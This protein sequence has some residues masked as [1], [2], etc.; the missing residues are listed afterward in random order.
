MKRGE[1]PGQWKRQKKNE[2]KELSLRSR[3]RA[4]GGWRSEGD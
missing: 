3:K 4:K 1:T 2:G